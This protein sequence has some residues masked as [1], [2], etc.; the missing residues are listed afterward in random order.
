M[1]DVTHPVMAEGAHAEGAFR[2]GQPVSVVFVLR[3]AP[4]VADLGSARLLRVQRGRQRVD[5]ALELG[6]AAVG[7]LLALARRRSRDAA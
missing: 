6:D 7:F 3:Y 1:R 2:H 4:M 5:L